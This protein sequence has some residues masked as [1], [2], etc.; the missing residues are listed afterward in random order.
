MFKVWIRR[1]GGYGQA[2]TKGMTQ[3]RAEKKAENIKARQPEG[4]EV[5]I[6]KA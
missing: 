2:V 3:E 5:W 1:N 4:T 6:E